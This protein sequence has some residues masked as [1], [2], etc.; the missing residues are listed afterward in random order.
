MLPATELT[1][2]AVRG[3]FVEP[4]AGRTLDDDLGDGCA[5]LLIHD[6]RRRPK[7]QRHAGYWCQRLAPN[8]YRLKS[9]SAPQSY[10]V[11]LKP[12][13][14]GCSCG[15]AQFRWRRPGGCRHQAALRQALEA[16]RASN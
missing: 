1:P 3:C 15:D 2:V 4:R 5:I 12:S 11:C 6:P 14:A 7:K 13:H 10:E 16:H 8:S 9:F